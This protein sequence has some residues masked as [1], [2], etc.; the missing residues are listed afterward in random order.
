MLELTQMVEDLIR[1]MTT[2]VLLIGYRFLLMD[3]QEIDEI[4][5][6]VVGWG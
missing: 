6:V 5:R 4:F 1:A 2:L 3:S